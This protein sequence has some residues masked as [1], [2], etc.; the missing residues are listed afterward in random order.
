MSY[1]ATQKLFFSS[2]EFAVVGASTVKEKTGTRVLRWYLDRN[3]AVT[4]VHPKEPNLEGI[5]TVKTLS[6]LPHPTKTS[7]SIIT[8]PKVT[9]S[10]LK[11]GNELGIPAFWL[12]PGAEDEAVRQYVDENGLSSKVV[13]GGPCVLVDGD[14]V[15]RSLL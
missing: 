9:L 1:S 6:K 10:I 8:P 14:G 2:P 5:N 3:K 15:T 11:E 7:I 13:L 4:P 12:Q